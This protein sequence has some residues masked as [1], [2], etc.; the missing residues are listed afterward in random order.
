M[1]YYQIPL[2]YTNK[3]TYYMLGCKNLISLVSN[4]RCKI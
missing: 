1:R 3:S 2:Q 4:C